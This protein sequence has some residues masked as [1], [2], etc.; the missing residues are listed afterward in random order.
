MKFVVKRSEW[1]RG[2]IN[3]PSKLL[4]GKNDKCCLGFLSLACGYTTEEIEEEVAPGL[5]VKTLN[6][7][8]FPETIADLAGTNTDL[9]NS[10]MFVND[11]YHYASDTDREI[12]LTELFAEGG[13]EVTFED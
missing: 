1:S 9:T 11:S 3:E 4:N 12:K 13:I 10:L 7:N 8:L 5:V 6:K 2:K